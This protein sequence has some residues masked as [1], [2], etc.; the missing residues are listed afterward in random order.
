M[1]FFFRGRT[2]QPTDLVKSLKDQI[3][4][5]HEF[6]GSAK[7]SLYSFRRGEKRRNFSLTIACVDSPGMIW[8]SKCLN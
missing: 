1:A 8:P 5:L 4:R 3:L 2:R 6:P 7:V